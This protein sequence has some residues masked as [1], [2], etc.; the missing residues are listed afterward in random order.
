MRSLFRSLLFAGL[1]VAGIC[2][3]VGVALAEPGPVSLEVASGLDGRARESIWAPVLVTVVNHG[4]TDLRGNLVVHMPGSISAQVAKTDYQVELLLPAGSQKTVSVPV[5]FTLA[6]SPSVTFESDGTTLARA[7]IRTTILSHELVMAGILSDEPG[8]FQSLSGA[9]IPGRQRVETVR[10]TAAALPDDPLLLQSL[11]LLAIGRFD[12]TKLTAKQRQALERWVKAGGMLILSAGPAWRTTQSGLP[13]SLLPVRGTEIR[14]RAAPELIAFGGAPLAESVPMAAG[15]LQMGAPV[16]GTAQA[17]WIAVADVGAG[18]VI[19]LAFDETLEPIHSWGGL[20]NMWEQLL[21]PLTLLQEPGAT[22]LLG[23]GVP[24]AGAVSALRRMP[25]FGLPQPRTA[26]ALLLVYGVAIGPGLYAALRRWDRREWAWAAV[27]LLAAL[28]LGSLYLVGY[29]SRGGGMHHTVT[30]TQVLPDASAISQTYMAA[31]TPARESIQISLP[32]GVFASGLVLGENMSEFDQASAVIRYGA[33]TT[34]DLLDSNRWE[35]RGFQAVSRTELAGSFTLETLSW[36]GRRLSGVLTNQTGLFLRNVSVVTPQGVHPVGDLA[37]G[38]RVNIAVP[39]VQAGGATPLTH[40]SRIFSTD[41]AEM[42]RRDVAIHHFS[43]NPGASPLQLTVLGWADEPP[44][45]TP[46]LQ[47][48]G[49]PLTSTNMVYARLAPEIR[50]TER[51][52]P[53]G[54][55]VGHLTN[56]HL[57][58]PPVVS[59]QGMLAAPGF[60]SFSFELPPIDRTSIDAVWL[61]FGAPG[62][63]VSDLAFEIELYHWKTRQWLKVEAVEQQPLDPWADFV[64]PS[65]LV[66][67]RLNL[68]EQANIPMPSLR[69]MGVVHP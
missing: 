16:V 35:L 17:P 42:R 61:H 57:V 40:F 46:T 59:D 10:F 51:E 66:S 63:A 53:P 38:A 41:P 39:L 32:D 20:T 55:I 22:L 27:P 30:I 12:S 28:S 6:F 5:F 69:V 56:S 65:G 29:R 37:S 60:Y 13:E 31:F 11:D 19:Y 9:R 52:I 24:S 44:A 36:D 58:Q 49:R 54:V 43:R 15:P 34:L 64:S 50:L 8:A 68:R 62:Q 21:A 14:Q 1:F 67:M 7:P 23:S 3:A 25:T 26:L 48:L 18:Q 2:T 45:G 33:E 4:E 47:G